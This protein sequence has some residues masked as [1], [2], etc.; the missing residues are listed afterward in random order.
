MDGVSSV[1]GHCLSG[2]AVKQRDSDKTPNNQ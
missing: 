1:P 2:S